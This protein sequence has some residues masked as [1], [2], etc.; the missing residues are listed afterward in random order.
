M[1][2]EFLGLQ[3]KLFTRGWLQSADDGEIEM[4]NIGCESGSLDGSVRQLEVAHLLLF[5]VWLT[6]QRIDLGLYHG[7]IPWPHRA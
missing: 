4:P 2:V 3:H 5:I 7:L 1:S 6:V